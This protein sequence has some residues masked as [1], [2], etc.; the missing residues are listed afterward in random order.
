METIKRIGVKALSF[1]G[2]RN[3]IYLFKKFLPG[4]PIF[5]IPV[6]KKLCCLTIDDGPGDSLENNYKILSI[7]KKYDV[8]ATF[9]I[10][11]TN[12]TKINENKQFMIDL[13]NDGHEIGNH[14]TID[15]KATEYSEQLFEK[16]LL[17]CEEVLSLYDK[18]FKTKPIKCFRPPCGKFNK[19]M[20]IIL[21]K[22]NYQNILGDVY[23]CDANINDPDFHLNFIRKNLKNG[24]IIILHFPKKDSRIQTIEILEK[25]IPEIKE[26]GFAFLTIRETLENK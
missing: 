5:S 4:Q 12:V 14:M 1:F 7:L 17:D 22:H 19:T 6:E 13:I 11:S 10:I 16:E 26:K 24:S 8:K 2:V 25:I 18:N 21:Q 15:E 23:S 20:N 3:L 9:F